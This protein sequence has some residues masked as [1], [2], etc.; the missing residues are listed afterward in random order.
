[1]MSGRCCIPFFLMGMSL[2]FSCVEEDVFLEKVVKI[3]EDKEIEEGRVFQNK[4]IYSVMKANYLWADKMRDS[5]S[6]DYSLLPDAFFESLLVSEDRFS[7]L[8]T[9]DQYRPATRG[10]NLNE[11]VRVDSVFRFED[12]SVGYFYYSGFETEADVTDVVIKFKGIDDLV[13]DV[14]DNP[15]GYVKT[16]RY[17]T[18]LIV[19]PCNAG[20]LFC[21]YEYNSRIS[22]ENK[23]KTGDERTYDYLMDTERILQRNLNLSRVYILVGKRSA[24]ASELLINSLRPYMDV[25]VIGDRTVGKDV[26]MRSFQNNSCQYILHPITF[27]TYNADNESVPTSGIVPDIYVGGATSSDK[28]GTTDDLLLSR[29]LQEI[30]NN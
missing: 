10:T 18:S 29:A 20:K 4:W 8:E 7:Y 21:S 16:C 12:R 9:N 15:G 3:D 30:R 17:L 19:P 28:L 22:A 2:L 11:T 24:S 5:S 23:M 13:V 6:Y 27:R 1:M 26:G 14:R 25:I